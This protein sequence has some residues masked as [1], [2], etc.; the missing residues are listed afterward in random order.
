VGKS[1]QDF[2]AQAMDVSRRVAKQ[3][4]DARV[5]WVN[6][7]CVWMARH[8]LRHGD[9]VRLTT[10]VASPTALSNVPKKL[11]VL[12]E[13]DDF[14]AVDKPAGILANESDKSAE[15]ILRRQTGNPDLRAVHR[16]DRDTTG[17]LLMAK[18]VE[19]KEAAVEVFRQH[20]VTKVY[21]AI[22]T[23]RWDAKTST[24]DLPIEGERA[25][26]HVT[27]VHANDMA[28]YLIVRIETGRTH[29]IRRH[30]A[31][32]RHPVL[33]DREYGPKTVLPEFQDVERA[34][35]HAVEL[36]LTHPTKPEKILKMFAPIPKDMHHWLN[37]LKLQ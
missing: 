21:R 10:V 20:Q 25:M 11:T 7:R 27:C 32:A 12:F 28:S 23:A 22:V 16:L 30:L 3:Q 14:L 8:S 36:M 26:T 37:I 34:M 19:A 15:A 35:L 24:L 18:S 33:G 29:Q 9:E 1:L 6:G 4:V 2:L 5:V 13:D 17:C 31:M